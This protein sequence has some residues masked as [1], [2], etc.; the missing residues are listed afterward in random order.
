M[1]ELSLSHSSCV[2]APSFSRYD[3]NPVGP[4]TT[5]GTLDG[6]ILA[7]QRAAASCF[8]RLAC[9]SAL[10]SSQIS[11]VGDLDKFLVPPISQSVVISDRV[12]SPP[13]PRTHRGSV[14]NSTP[15]C[16]GDDDFKPMRKI[17]IL[18]NRSIRAAFLLSAAAFVQPTRTSY[19]T[20]S[21]RQ[22]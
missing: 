7:R 14:H 18:R 17:L 20:Q 2:G 9:V 13:G 6:S 5:G 1:F 16:S 19:L 21:E 11:L 3:V 4:R 15:V 8:R 12:N 22:V 10:H